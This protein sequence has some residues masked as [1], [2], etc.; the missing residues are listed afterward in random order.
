MAL[1]THR[2]GAA[3]SELPPIVLLH[4]F[5][6]SASDDFVAPGWDAALS[7]AGRT[8]IAVDLPGHGGGPAISGAAEATTSAVVAAILEAAFAEVPEGPVDVIGYSLGG[9]LG[10][11]LPAASDRVRRVVLGGVSPFEP[12]GAVDPAELAS[13]L[14]GEA[15]QNPLVGMMAGMIS[16]P[17]RDTASLAQLIPGLASEPFTPEAGGPTVPTL[18]IAG[19]EDQMTQGIETLAEA[20]PDATLTRVPGDH[21][22][23]LRSTE[24]RDAALAFLA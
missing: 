1:T 16:Q 2:L 8:G 4:G 6:S 18:L 9:R 7:A 21:I 22:G 13:V 15:P 12:F 5:A 17:G 14:S 24:L 23:A 20:L 19:T 3:S 11:E 10:W